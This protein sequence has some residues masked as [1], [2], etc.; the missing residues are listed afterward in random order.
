[1]R[2]PILA[3]VRGRAGASRSRVE[4][5]LGASSWSELPYGVTSDENKR[6]TSATH[7]T[8][9]QIFPNKPQ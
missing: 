2:Q 8:V 7:A 1:M 4:C 9:K 3:R 5:A 6:A